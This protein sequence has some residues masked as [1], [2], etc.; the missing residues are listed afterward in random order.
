MKKK[1][2][3]TFGRRKKKQQPSQTYLNYS[4]EKELF[5][6]KRNYLKG[7]K[8]FKGNGNYLNEEKLKLFTAKETI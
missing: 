7:K 8:V 6:G 2:F 4:H 3:E 5:K 1:T